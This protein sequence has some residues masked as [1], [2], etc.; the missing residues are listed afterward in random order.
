MYQSCIR[1]SIA[2]NCCNPYVC[3]KCGDIGAGL[4]CCD[5]GDRQSIHAKRVVG[6]HPIRQPY[7]TQG[8]AQ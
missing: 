4:Y 8:D 7:A 6:P 5:Y 1:Y 2:R 3:T